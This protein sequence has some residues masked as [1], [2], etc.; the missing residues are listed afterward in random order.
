LKKFK[1]IKFKKRKLSKESVKITNSRSYENEEFKKI[2]KSDK[3]DFKKKI[4]KTLREEL[5]MMSKILKNNFK[6][7]INDLKR[8]KK[9]I[10]TLKKNWKS[11]RK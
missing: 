1:K 7:I 11:L 2:R 5:N 3:I 9:L 4:L 8:I 10:K 6:N